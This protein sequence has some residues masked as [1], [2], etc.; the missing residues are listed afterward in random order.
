MFEANTKCFIKA[1][2]EALA[3]LIG[4]E[5]KAEDAQGLR[6]T[7]TQRFVLDGKG[8]IFGNADSGVVVEAK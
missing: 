1:A 8:T 4:C 3:H 7:G 5:C 2:P 6:G